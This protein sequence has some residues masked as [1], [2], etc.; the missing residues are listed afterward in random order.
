VQNYR[1]PIATLEWK[2]GGTWVAVPRTSYNYFVDTSG[3]G[4]GT[5]G[6]RIT[7]WDGEALEDTLPAIDAGLVATGSGQF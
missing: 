7:A 3:M 6:V 5:V 2:S 1:L 4:T